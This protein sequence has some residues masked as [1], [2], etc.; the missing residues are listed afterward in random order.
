M[1]FS[2][3]Y[4]TTAILGAIRHCFEARYHPKPKVHS[5]HCLME[6]IKNEHGYREVYKVKV[7]IDKLKLREFHFISSMFTHSS[8][9]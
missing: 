4:S 6:I 3:I 2:Y 1:K 7:N 9:N 8:R 5:F